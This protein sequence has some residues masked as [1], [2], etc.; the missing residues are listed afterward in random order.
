[1][2]AL[3]ADMLPVN[4]T[5]PSWTPG[6]AP[7]PIAILGSTGSVGTQTVEVAEQ[8][9]ERVRVAA[10]CGGKN[11]DLLIE[12]AWR[13]KPDLIVSNDPALLDREVP[14]GSRVVMGAEGMIE[15]ATLPGVQIVVTASSGHAAIVPTA[16]AIRAGKCIALANK[17]TIVCAGELILP[18][19][20]EN[21]VALRPVDSEHSAIWQSL[22]AARGSG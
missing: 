12:Q 18:L 8:M 21:G 5:G 19:A 2:S 14:L 16:E 4:R 3:T 13:L 10:L 1:M 11:T 22:S 7:I 15:A 6:D 20:E 9:P 17:E